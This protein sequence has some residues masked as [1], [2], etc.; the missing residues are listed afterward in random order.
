MG[1]NLASL[2]T[3]SAARDPERTAIKLDDA[4]LTFAQLDGAS[5]RFAGLLAAARLPAGRPRRA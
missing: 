1:R 2:L 5:A 4:E 3:D